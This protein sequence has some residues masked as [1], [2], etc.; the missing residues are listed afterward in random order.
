MKQNYFIVVLAH[1]LHGRLRRIQVPHTVV[2]TFF[3]LA[4]LGGLTVFKEVRLARPDEVRDVD[5]ERVVAAPVRRRRDA[6]HP[7]G[8][9]PV[10]RSEVEQHPLVAQTLNHM[11]NVL[12][13]QGRFVDDP[14]GVGLATNLVLV[15]DRRTI[16]RSSGWAALE[17][18]RG[19]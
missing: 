3:A 12:I 5:A 19:L 9:V 18:R 17:L 4:L 16:R 15:T 10:H 8:R 1:S 7:H 2:S 13:L 11:G 14:H 6:V